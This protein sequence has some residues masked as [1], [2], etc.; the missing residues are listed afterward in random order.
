M[1]RCR[2]PKVCCRVRKEVR[3]LHFLDHN[4]KFHDVKH[5]CAFAYE[6]HMTVGRVPTKAALKDHSQGD[7]ACLICSQ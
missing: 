1:K 2:A 7:P 6:R 4:D 3:A 5:E